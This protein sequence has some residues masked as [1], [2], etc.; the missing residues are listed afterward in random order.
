[1]FYLLFLKKD[2]IKKKLIDLKITN[3]LKF[4]KVK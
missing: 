4:K 2:I 3:L 1:M